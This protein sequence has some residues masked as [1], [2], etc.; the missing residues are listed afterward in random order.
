M[1]K[2]MQCTHMIDMAVRQDMQRYILHPQPHLGQLRSRQ[3]LRSALQ[4]FAK[5]I[6][7]VFLRRSL[8][9]LGIFC[10]EPGIDQHVFAGIGPDQ[11]PAN[12]NNPLIGMHLE[13]AIIQ[14]RQRQGPPFEI[15]FGLHVQ[16]S[17]VAP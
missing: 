4:H 3:V 16:S 6:K 14:N 15:A 17:P 9:I 2:V 7:A 13:Q 5:L 11:I 10:W 8:R 1:R 12:S